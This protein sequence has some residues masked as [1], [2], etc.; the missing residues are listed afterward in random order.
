MAVYEVFLKKAG[1]DPLTH[2]GS[3]N[4]LDDEMALLFARDC[5]N[6]RGEGDQMWVVKRD[7]LLPADEQDLQISD[8]DHR[9]SDGQLLIR[10]RKAAGIAAE[11]A[12]E[13]TNE[14]ANE[15]TSKVAE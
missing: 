8:R 2:A 7:N 12:A 9:H 11:A 5:Y 14:A 6:R 13:T 1:K 15:A 4:A 10:L 3:L